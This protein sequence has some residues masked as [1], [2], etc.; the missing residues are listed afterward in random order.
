MESQSEVVEKSLKAGN[1][2]N[3]QH[4]GPEVETCLQEDAEGGTLGY[5][6]TKGGQMVWGPVGD[7]TFTRCI[8]HCLLSIRSFIQICNLCKL[9]SDSII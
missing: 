7:Q 8:F 4:K 3:S 2:G 5:R 6:G 1:K 9:N